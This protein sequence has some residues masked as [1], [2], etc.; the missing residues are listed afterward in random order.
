MVHLLTRV[1]IEPAA[2]HSLLQGGLLFHKGHAIQIPSRKILLPNIHLWM[3]V[4]AYA[5]DLIINIHKSYVSLRLS[6]LHYCIAI[7]VFCT[8]VYRK[9]SA[10]RRKKV[11]Y[12]VYT[13]VY[14]NQEI[15]CPGGCACM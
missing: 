4:S 9:K 6:H 3:D 2:T 10:Y 11:A 5:V 13:T 14:R 1:V 12:Y 15:P 7:C 8:N